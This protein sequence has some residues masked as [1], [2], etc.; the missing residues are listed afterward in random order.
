MTGRKRTVFDPGW[1]IVTKVWL[2]FI[3][4]LLFLFQRARTN[5]LVRFQIMLQWRLIS[6]DRIGKGVLGDSARKDGIFFVFIS[7]EVQMIGQCSLASLELRYLL[8]ISTFFS[9]YPS[10]LFYFLFAFTCNPSS[11]LTSLG[12]QGLVGGL[13]DSKGFLL[14]LLLAWSAEEDDSSLEAGLAACV[15]AT[16]IDEVCIIHGRRTAGWSRRSW[17]LL[18]LDRNN[19]RWLEGSAFW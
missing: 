14:N 10:S 18:I 17:G 5:G 6:G 15:C 3:K 11:K 9:V 19:G 13:N 12:L 7:V 1:R 8:F 2:H 4:R 16:S